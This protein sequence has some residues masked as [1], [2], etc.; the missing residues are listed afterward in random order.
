MAGV[1]EFEE[2]L[3]EEF[4]AQAEAQLDEAMH[5]LASENSELWEEL[6]TLAQS[7]GQSRSGQA[8]APRLAAMGSPRW[9]LNWRR[10]SGN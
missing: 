4:A 3:S 7:V 9:M 2:I 10:P 5:M 1:E 6:E 8:A